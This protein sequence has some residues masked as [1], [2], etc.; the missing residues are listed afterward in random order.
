MVIDKS[1]RASPLYIYI[2]MYI[3]L[4]IK[5]Y[6]Y[7]VNEVEALAPTFHPATDFTVDKIPDSC[8]DLRLRVSW[9]NT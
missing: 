3:H 4:V 7:R 6:I 2:Y 8:F 1:I 9:K 5:A